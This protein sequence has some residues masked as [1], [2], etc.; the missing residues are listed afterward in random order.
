MGTVSLGGC[1]NHL[2]YHWRKTI[3]RTEATKLTSFLSIQ[4][5]PP[6]SFRKGNI[7]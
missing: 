6:P 3:V 2:S 1:G 7:N 5:L 4:Q